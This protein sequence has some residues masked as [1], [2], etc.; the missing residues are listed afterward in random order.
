MLFLSD[1]FSMVSEVLQHL[2]RLRVDNASDVY[3]HLM[4]LKLVFCSPTNG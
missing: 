1:C 4:A 3:V 2:L